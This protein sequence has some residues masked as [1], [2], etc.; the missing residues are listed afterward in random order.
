MLS[1][2]KSWSP[3]HRG[4][5]YL[6]SG[7]LVLHVVGQKFISELVGAALKHQLFC[8]LAHFRTWCGAIYT[9]NPQLGGLFTGIW[10]GGGFF[11]P[12]RAPLC[13]PICKGTQ[14]TLTFFR[15]LLLVKCRSVSMECSHVR[16]STTIERRTSPPCCL[17]SQSTCTESQLRFYVSCSTNKRI[18]DTASHTAYL[19]F[20][21]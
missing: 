10:H 9:H 4:R 16:H 2:M 14:K 15:L 8:H 7:M 21:L 3:K 5:L 19:T 18:A 12:R 13:S 1:E 11:G 20:D 17:T 6:C